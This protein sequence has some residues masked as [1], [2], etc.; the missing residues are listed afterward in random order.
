M[1]GGTVLADV[2]PPWRRRLIL[3]G[4]LRP[5]T[6]MLISARAGSHKRSRKDEVVAEESNTVAAGVDGNDATKRNNQFRGVRRRPWGKWA[7]EITDARK[8]ARVWLG[9]Y[10]TP[11]EAAK[12]YDAE[13][14]KIRGKKAKVNFPDEAPMASQKPIHVPTSLEVAKNAASSIQEPL[15]NISPDQGSNSFSTSNSSMKNDSRT[16]DITSVL[17]RI[18]TLT[19]D[20]ESA[21]LQDTANASMPVVT[22]DACV[23]HYELYMNFL[24]NSSDESTN[25]V[26]NYDDEPED[27]GSNMNLWNFD[28]MPMTGDIVF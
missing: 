16:T 26:L 11:E 14:R 10:N 23:D 19:E 6:K 27:V 5:D 15:V 25:T 9:T 8:G 1:C 2:P 20:D 17:A 24:M 22:S 21:F 3:A 7:A 12:A 18:P 28:D 4:R 13:A